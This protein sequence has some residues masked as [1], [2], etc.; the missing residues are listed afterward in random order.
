MKDAA[1]YHSPVGWLLLEADES[2]ITKVHFMDEKGEVS[3]SLSPVLRQCIAELDEYFSGKREG[4]SLPLRP[5]GTDFQQKVWKQL[6]NIPFA[7]TVS[8][9]QVAAQLGDLKSIRAVGT[10]NG[11][12]PLA[13]IIPCHRVIGRDGSLTG[14]GGGLWRKKWLLDFERKRKQGELF[15]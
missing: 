10:A 12:N 5:F 14:Y 9:S 13:I 3:A 11:R 8:Y 7:K 1:Y 6:L 15:G 4:F 2:A